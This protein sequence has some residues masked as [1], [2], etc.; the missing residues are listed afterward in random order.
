MTSSDLKAQTLPIIKICDDFNMASCTFSD[1][2][3]SCHGDDLG[4]SLKN[5]E[6][7]LKRT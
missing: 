5:D 2:S 6:E 7:A 4:E 3:S 1:Q